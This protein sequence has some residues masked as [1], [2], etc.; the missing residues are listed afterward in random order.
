[1]PRWY[2]L[3]TAKRRHR[4]VT[5]VATGSDQIEAAVCF[6]KALKVYPA[7]GK[8]SQAPIRSTHAGSWYSRIQLDPEMRAQKLTSCCR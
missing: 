8:R 4:W 2:G 7:P 3:L 6:Y 5:S 1:M